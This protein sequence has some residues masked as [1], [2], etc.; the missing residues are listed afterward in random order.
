MTRD[1]ALAKLTTL[2]KRK[3]LTAREIAVELGCCRPT[4]YQRV[5]ALI[6]AGEQVYEIKRR[7]EGT[8]PKAV[9]Y[10]IRA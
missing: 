10:G 7:Q 6:A 4:A 9:A 5:R 3:P 8:G 1:E 2:L